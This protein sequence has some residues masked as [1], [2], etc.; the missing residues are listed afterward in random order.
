MLNPPDNTTG[1]GLLLFAA[2][3]F[4]LTGYLAWRGNFYDAALWLAFAV[5]ITC[6]G[7]I[8]LNLFPR[9]HRLLLGIGLVAG[10]GVMWLALL[11]L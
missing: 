11:S 6:Y 9:L 10:G 5:C 7:F 1:R 8:I 3:M 4:G 2:L